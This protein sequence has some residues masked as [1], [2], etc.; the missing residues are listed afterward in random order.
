M[1]APYT[2]AAMLEP[3]SNQTPLRAGSSDDGISAHTGQALSLAG[4]ESFFNTHSDA[5]RLW[6]KEKSH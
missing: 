3:A 5:Q 4:N 1:L 2:P 6:Y